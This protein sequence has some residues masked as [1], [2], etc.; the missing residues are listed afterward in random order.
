MKSKLS[1]LIIALLAASSLTLFQGCADTSAP[2]GAIENVPVT[3]EAQ[4]AVTE[5]PETGTTATASGSTFSD[6]M[7]NP[8]YQ[9]YLGFNAGATKDAVDSILGEG[10]PMETDTFDGAGAEKFEY[11]MEGV[12]LWMTFRDGGLI[13]KSSQENTG[14]S[15]PITAEQFA[16]L[17]NDMTLNEVVALIGEGQLTNETYS[18]SGEV[19]K[20]YFWNV[21]TGYKSVTIM[22]VDDKV[23]YISDMNMD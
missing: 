7:N 6:L 5:T 21:D 22:F 3:N 4:P 17:K 13:S 1:L 18:G 10:T 19:R 14:W 8:G 9:A 11:S 15:T 16:Q 23:S 12:T 20:T 2:S